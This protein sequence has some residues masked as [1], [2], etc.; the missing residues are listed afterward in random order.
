MVRS[1]IQRPP[2]SPYERDAE[3]AAFLKEILPTR[4]YSA[5]IEECRARFGADRTP[6]R[7]SIQR[8]AARMANQSRL[9]DAQS[10]RR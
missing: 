1:L 9:P 8:F 4:V 5:A 10:S 2:R 7:S 3:V 6:S